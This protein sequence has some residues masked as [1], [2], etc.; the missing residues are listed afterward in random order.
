MWVRSIRLPPMSEH[1]MSEIRCAQAVDCNPPC[2]Q[3]KIT[4]CNKSCVERV[5]KSDWR[6]YWSVTGSDKRRGTATMADRV[7]PHIRRLEQT[8]R[9]ETLAAAK[10]RARVLRGPAKWHGLGR[11]PGGAT[12]AEWV[13]EKEGSLQKRSRERQGIFL[14]Q[15]GHLFLIR[16]A[17]YAYVGFLKSHFSILSQIGVVHV[18]SNS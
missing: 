9:A 17:L 18:T 13:R 6:Y 2:M 5:P 1:A 10:K 4:R 16:I 14:S 15:W 8:L 12:S 3:N 11:C 7:D